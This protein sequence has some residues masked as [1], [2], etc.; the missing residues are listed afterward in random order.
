M[1]GM[2]VGS[3]HQPHTHCTG[4][5]S[6][7]T[8]QG[9]FTYT[10]VH[11]STRVFAS[12]ACTP[13]YTHSHSHVYLHLHRYITQH[14]CS[15]MYTL[16]HIDSHVIAQSKTQGTAVFGDS[17]ADLRARCVAP[18]LLQCSCCQTGGQPE[19]KR[20]CLEVGRREKP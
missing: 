5:R 11:M 14:T 16:T 9:T 4:T 7:H 2:H 15:H 3:S 17:H 8:C 20:K 19:H 13:V 10:V 6:S 1:P 18:T 12:C